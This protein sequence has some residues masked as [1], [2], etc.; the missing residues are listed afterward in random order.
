MSCH[1][2]FM[3]TFRLLNIFDLKVDEESLDLRAER[4][5]APARAGA[6]GL[7]VSGSPSAG[8]RGC[9]SCRHTTLHQITEYNEITR[10]RGRDADGKENNTEEGRGAGGER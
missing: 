9:F 8:S 4:T 6:A 2:M 1:V 7:R 10:Q 5:T 3:F